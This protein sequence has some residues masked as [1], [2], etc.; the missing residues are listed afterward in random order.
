MLSPVFFENLDASFLI[1]SKVCLRDIGFLSTEWVSV[2]PS[3]AIQFRSVSQLE[4][5]SIGGCTG[6][7]L[8]QFLSCSPALRSVKM[9]DCFPVDDTIVSLLSERLPLLNEIVV[10]RSTQLRNA[11]FNSKNRSIKYLTLS[12]CPIL[13]NVSVPTSLISCA[14]NGTAVSDRV[15]E[16]ITRV[17]SSLILLDVS[18]CQ[19]LSETIVVSSTLSILKADYC[20]S[21]VS[22]H[23][24][25][26]LLQSISM[27]G[28]TS[29]V[30]LVVHS[31]S[32]N[33]IDLT[34]L[35]TLKCIELRCEYLKALQLCG[36]ESLK[37]YGR[38]LT[39]DFKRISLDT[40]R[41]FCPSVSF[42]SGSCLAGSPIY[43]E[44]IYNLANSALAH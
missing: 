43:D 21:V 10:S 16:E 26:P 36:C 20:T 5:Q 37:Y 8:L 7:A 25:C 28:C 44:Y 14:L 35:K 23:V 4:A 1:L 40:I 15:V 6:G 42:G 31:S 30:Q 12:M 33:S 38:Y 32:I 18:R 3:S 29:M 17:C 19:A 41:A 9:Y 24:E 27:S 34:M 11:L 2:P 13:R 39:E 22:M